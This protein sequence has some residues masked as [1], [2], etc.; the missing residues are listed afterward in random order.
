[1]KTAI[2][3]VFAITLG[4]AVFTVASIAA[5]DPLPPAV[6]MPVLKVTARPPCVVRALVQGTGTVRVC[7]AGVL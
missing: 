2:A 4:S 5:A 3:F 7:Q 6:V 1:M